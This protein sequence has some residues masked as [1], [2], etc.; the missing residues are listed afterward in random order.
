MSN[1]IIDDK[2]LRLL[3]DKHQYSVVLNKR[4]YTAIYIA[5]KLPLLT[6][7]LIRLKAKKL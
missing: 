4:V 6:H 7:A 5:E 2:C 3:T 1:I